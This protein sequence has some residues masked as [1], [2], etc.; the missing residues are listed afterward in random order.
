M[1]LKCNLFA[2]SSISAEYLQKFWIFFI[3][4]GSVATCLSW[5]G[6]C[7]MSFVANFIRFPAVQ[8]FYLS[9]K[10][11]QSYGGFKDGNLFWD[12][13]YVCGHLAWYWLHYQFANCPI[14]LYRQNYSAPLISNM[15]SVS[16]LA[17]WDFVPDCCRFFHYTIQACKLFYHFFGNFQR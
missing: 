10:I 14:N 13:V 7:Y 11:W 2:F 17:H 12:T 9:V 3:S 6:Y 4:Q 15:S 5:G 1:Y 16:L 8:K